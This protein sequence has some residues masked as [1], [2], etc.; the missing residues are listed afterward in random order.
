MEQER[1]IV[2]LFY[3]LI[4]SLELC[5]FLKEIFA[6]IWIFSQTMLLQYFV[7]L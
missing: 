2:G 7:L 4:Q 1:S 5:F 6:Q 3:N